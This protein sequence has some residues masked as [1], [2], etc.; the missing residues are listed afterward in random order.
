MENINKLHYEV[1]YRYLDG[2]T[3]RRLAAFHFKFEAEKYI[4]MMHGGDKDQY[5][6]VEP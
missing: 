3:T 5:F 1:W 4:E 6:I 2:V